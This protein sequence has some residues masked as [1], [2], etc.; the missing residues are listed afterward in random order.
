MNGEWVDVGGGRLPVDNPGTSQPVT[1]IASANT[2]DIDRAVGAA[3]ACHPSGVLTD[4]RPVER[5]MLVRKIGEDLLA[6]I[7]EIAESLTLGSGKPLLES[8]IEIEGAARYFEYYGNQS[9]TLK[10]RSIPLGADYLD[11]TIYEPFAV[12]AQIITRNCPME[13]TACGIAAV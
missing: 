12:S 2:A 5:S 7:D 11:F 8:L 3:A 1:K 13:M 9:E 10:G 4:M 6:N